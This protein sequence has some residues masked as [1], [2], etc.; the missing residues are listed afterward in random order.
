[1][2]TSTSHID[3]P[4]WVPDASSLPTPEQ[5]RKLGLQS[6]TAI[7]LET[8]GIDPEREV[9]I[10]WGAQRFVDGQLDRAFQTFVQ[11]GKPVPAEIVQLTSITDHDVADAPDFAEANRQFGEF[12]KSTPVVGHHFDFDLGFLKAST[13]RSLPHAAPYPCKGK[14]V[15]DTSQ[16]VR[17]VLPSETGYGLGSLVKSRGIIHRKAHRALDDAVATGWLFLMLVKE[18]LELDYQTVATQLRFL[19]GSRH[20]LQRFLSKLG[21][22]LAETE[23]TRPITRMTIGAPETVEELEEQAL[24][25]EAPDWKESDY[26]RIFGHGGEMSLAFPGFEERSQ[27]AQMAVAAYQAFRDNRF[28]CVEAGT[29]T[30]KSLAYLAPALA[31]AASGKMEK[32]RVIISTGTKNLQDHLCN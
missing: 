26:R 12:W 9:I 27:Q 29:G 11:P 3:A 6:F 25:T 28:L 32:R 30:G 4:S 20:P 14:P 7:D 1:M 10:E 5:L 15:Y 13:K 22:Y 31:W 24:P 16:L 2:A 18:A 8:T 19:E 23:L 17:V 21:N